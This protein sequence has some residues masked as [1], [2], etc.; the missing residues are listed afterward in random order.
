MTPSSADSERL[1]IAARA[2]SREAL[3]QALEACRL[4]LLGVADRELDAQLRAKGGASDLVQETFLEAQRDFARF[5][6]HSEQELLAWL[7]QILRNNL[8]NFARRYRGT[9]KRDADREVALGGDSGTGPSPPA[10]T[11]TPSRQLMMDEQNQQLLQ[12]IGRLPPDYARI[13]TLRY[14]EERSFEEIATLMQRSDNAVRKLFSRA[15]ALLE[16][17]L[18]TLS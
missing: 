2:G 17:E 4:Y 11:P 7:R 8:L 5:E 12:A 16:K 3:G 14:L 1:L 13:L 9:D 18:D 10:A 15:V 6:G